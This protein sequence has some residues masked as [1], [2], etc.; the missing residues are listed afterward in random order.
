MEAVSKI[1]LIVALVSWGYSLYKYLAAVEMV[2]QS[3][4]AEDDVKF[5][6]ISLQPTKLILMS[7]PLFTLSLISKSYADKYRNNQE[8]LNGFNLARKYLLF[9]LLC[10]TFV[11]ITIIL[12]KV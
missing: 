1:F 5:L 4:G 10:M 12:S 3:I 2:A 6:G 8:L 9:M 7:T 11:F